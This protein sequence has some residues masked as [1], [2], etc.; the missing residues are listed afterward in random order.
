MIY[1]PDRISETTLCVLREVGWEL[2]PVDLIEPPDHGKGIWPAFIDQYTKLR[3]WTLDKIGVKAA[4]YLDADTLVKQ[5]FDELFELPF[6]FAA[7][8]DVFTDARGFTTNFNAGV[9][10][11]KPDSEVFADM[12][13]KVES[14]HFDRVAAE[15]SYLNLYYGSQVLKLPHV[16]NGNLAIKWRAQEYWKAMQEQLRIIHYTL[17]KPFDGKVECAKET[18][19]GEEVFGVEKRRDFLAVAEKAWGGRFKDEVGEWGVVFEE[20]MKTVGDQCFA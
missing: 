5:N 14:A 12:L 9:M 6:V 16:Y 3:V 18:C 10:V 11:F 1:L 17:V 7:V 19:T 13:A 2:F 4:V 8:P 20:V 15:Q